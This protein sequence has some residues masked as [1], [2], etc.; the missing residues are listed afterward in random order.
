[1][2]PRQSLFQFNLLSKMCFVCGS[3]LP[4]E[5]RTLKCQD[6]VSKQA[7][8]V[9]QRHVREEY[10]VITSPQNVRGGTC[11]CPLEQSRR[12]IIVYSLLPIDT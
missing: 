3:T 8:I 7:G 2:Y 11:S 12:T 5:N 4:G 10:L 9:D 1:M 6:G